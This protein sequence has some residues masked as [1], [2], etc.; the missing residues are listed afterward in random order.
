MASVGQTASVRLP[1]N[2]RH[3]LP[4]ITVATC[5]GFIKLGEVS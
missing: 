5:N 2:E 3:S 4:T 1:F